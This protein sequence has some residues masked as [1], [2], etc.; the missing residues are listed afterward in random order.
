MAGGSVGA[1][2][3]VPA[4]EIE[5]TVAPVEIDGTVVLRLRGVS[6]LPAA[7]RARLVRDRIIAIADNPAIAAESL[8]IAD[9]D[10]IT[11]II[12]N[13]TTVVGIT[14]ADASL[15]Q[16]QRG[17]LALAHVA[18]LRQVILDYRQA[19]SAAALRRAAFESGLATILLA[20]AILLVRWLRRRLDRVLTQ[21]LQ[22]RI[23]TVGIQSLELMRAERIWAAL[24][25]A[26]LALQ[27]V[28]ILAIAFV[29][30]GFVLARF[31]ATRGVSRDMITF[32]LGPVQV[33]VSGIVANIPSLT[34]L[35][36]LFLVLR[37]ALRVIGL[38]FEAIE[39]G[40]I[41]L[42]N[43]DRE[44]AQP[45]YKIARL[46]VI[47]F[48]LI[49]AYP[50]VPGSNS[51]AFKGVSLFIGVVFSLGSSSAISNIIAGYMMTYRRA[52]RLGDRIKVGANVGDVIEM[53]LQ[54][55]HLRSI[56]NE[57]IIIPNSQVLTG[58]V[59]NYSSLTRA[60]G[61]ILHTR[62]GIG[63]ETPWRQVE[64]MLLLAAERTAGLSP[65]PPFVLEVGLGDFAVIYELNVFCG[66]ARNMEYLYAELHRHILDVFNEYGVQIM[67]PAY[68][69]DPLEP[70]VVMQKDWYA[71]PAA[72]VG[73]VVS[74]LDANR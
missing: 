56:K 8:Y 50:Y 47:A 22:E 63:Y 12:A 74:R 29:Y 2:S 24:Q 38:F 18:R 68:H 34:F 3:S 10:G 9:R 71:A 39:G 4:D 25:H 37:L 43:F 26:V 60:H 57:E 59:V 69:A 41:V 35:L 17:E 73:A 28:A 15:E 53:R 54:V 45:T 36:V 64:G 49:V 23:H 7:E 16:V 42:A 11:R 27:T 5:P 13:N 46:A 48:G 19:R 58:D 61:L 20:I 66:D 31:P 1:Q 40:R 52:F 44:W 62:V 51:A 21:R 33:I 30:L 67:T 6:S 65:E 55:T 70:K 72:A 14:D 32:A